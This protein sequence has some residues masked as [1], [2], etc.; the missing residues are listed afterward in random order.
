MILSSSALT[1]H[2]IAMRLHDRFGLN[3][4]PRELSQ[5]R[6][7][8]ADAYRDLP[9]IYPW[10]WYNRRFLLST[11]PKATFTVTYD[12]T[13]GS[14]ERLVTITSGTAPLD[15][16]YGE[17]IYGDKFYPIERRISSTQFTLAESAYPPNDFT[18]TQVTWVRS[19]YTLPSQI[20]QI[21]EAWS[22][23]QN[24]KLTYIP[25]QEMSRYYLI[26]PN[27]GVAFYFNIN[28]SSQIL[29]HSALKLYPAPDASEQFEINCAVHTTPLINFDVTGTDGVATA[30]S[31][32]TSASGPFNSSMVG[33]VLRLTYGG[34][35]PKGRM[36]YDEKRSVYE[37][38]YLIKRFVSSTEI[39]VD[40][41]I[42]TGT[43]VAFQVSDYVDIGPDSLLSA[44]EALAHE[45]FCYN[46]AVSGEETGRAAARK[47]QEI[48]AAIEADSKVNWNLEY[49]LPYP[50]IFDGSI[51]NFD[52]L[53][54]H[55]F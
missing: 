53:K 48:R 43:D 4:S 17:I 34:K 52:S 51:I 39:Q 10:K 55:T 19:N 23:S 13:G 15:L 45:K 7:A 21:H 18:A 8:V 40:G 47:T 31:T 6:V 46:H 37:E 9:S 12:V 32:F 50:Y 11:S 22:A 27:T 42:K 20:R 41:V 29:G 1:Y 35:I 3:Q 54:K 49:S 5:V 44:F 24:R 28:S 14:S 30:V 26:S 33:S 38:Q 16:E 36:V 25:F 2:D